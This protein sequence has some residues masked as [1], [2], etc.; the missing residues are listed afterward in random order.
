MCS[1]IPI[2]PEIECSATDGSTALIGDKVTP[3]RVLGVKG[4]AVPLTTGKTARPWIGG[5]PAL[6][7]TDGVT[8]VT[9]RDLEDAA[10][11]EVLG[12]KGVCGSLGN[13]GVCEKLLSTPQARLDPAL[14]SLDRAGA[15]TRRAGTI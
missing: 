6:G 15:V 3:A 9:R 10:M 5:R 11:S 14:G 8:P 2:E 4:S 1:H 13:K 7:L 12:N